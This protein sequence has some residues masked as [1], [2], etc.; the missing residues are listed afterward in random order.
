LDS[1]GPHKFFWELHVRAVVGW[2]RWRLRKFRKF[3]G[4]NKEVNQ[5]KIILVTKD[6]SKGRV[7][8]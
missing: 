5:D 8:H 7:E 1:V 2:H 4:L 3:G 6:L